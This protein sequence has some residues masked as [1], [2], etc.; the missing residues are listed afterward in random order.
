MYMD[1]LLSIKWKTNPLC[2]QIALFHLPKHPPVPVC[3]DRAMCPVSTSVLCI[4]YFQFRVFQHHCGYVGWCVWGEGVTFLL[5]HSPLFPSLSL[6]FS[7]LHF[8][9][10]LPFS[11]LPSPS[12]STLPSLSIF[13]LALAKHCY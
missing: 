4:N 6:P 10:F 13:F 12:F 3:L 5:Y 11:F 9:S 2:I 7:F 8:P 1:I